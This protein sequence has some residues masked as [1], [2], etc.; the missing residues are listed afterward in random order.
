MKKITNMMLVVLLL[1]LT[2]CE[3][4][5]IGSGQSSSIESS[6]SSCFESSSVVNKNEANNLSYGEKLAT[7]IESSYITNQSFYDYI[8]NDEE[9]ID[10][11]NVVSNAIYVSSTGDGNGKSIDDPCSIYDA[12]DKV[13][14]GQTI[15]LRGGNY[16]L[17][18]TI[19]LNKSGSE[20]N[21]ITIRNYPGEHVYLSSSPENVA[22]Y[23]EDHEYVVF[24]LEKKVSYIKIEGLEIGNISENNVIGIVAWDG[25]QNNII[26]RNNI[27]HDLKT[28]STNIND[29]DA[30]ANAILL[31]GESKTSIN[32]ILIYGNECYNNKTGWSETISVAGNCESIY[33]IENYVHDN[34]NIGID[35]YG[36]AGY[37]SNKALDQPRSCVAAL[38]KIDSSVCEYADAA[39]LYVDGAKDI[40]L[41]NNI[42][43]NSQY[44]IEIGAEELSEGYPVKNIIVR[45]NLIYDNLTCGLR[46]GGYDEKKCGYVIDTLIC[47]NTIINSS[48]GESGLIT[49]SKVD[50][51]EFVNN[52]VYTETSKPLVITDMTRTYSKN[53]SFIN[54]YCTDKTKTKEEFEFGLFKETQTGLDSFNVITSNT[55]ITGY[56]NFGNMYKVLDGVT[57][58]AGNSNIACGIYDIEF[59]KRIHND[60]ID[61]GA[62]E[63]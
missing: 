20:N 16:D 48:D 57:I 7:F 19:Y 26:I 5:I 28:S 59:K 35:F 47:N 54:N 13:K 17:E 46:V 21:Y 61:I 45:N 36:N 62:Y 18:G 31:L 43:T 3:Y 12:V 23:N 50:G 30:G 15:Y 9:Y 42:I 60:C 39:G 63:L 1:F 56:I 32:N 11:S 52:L 6:I 2:S 53:I 25:G 55:N 33:V 58:N 37:C 4:L 51:I 29:E 34:S 49:I 40:L 24:A 44:G 14:A 8:I 38:N 10:N 22:K 41:T 27:I